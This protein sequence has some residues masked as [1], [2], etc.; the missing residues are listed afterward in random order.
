MGESGIEMD[1]THK[2]E[3]TSVPKV[4]PINLRSIFGK[5]SGPREGGRLLDS[6]KSQQISVLFRS[7]PAYS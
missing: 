6:L 3:R 4:G 2:G 1:S 7:L 5:Q